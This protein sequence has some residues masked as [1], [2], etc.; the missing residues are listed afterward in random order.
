MLS[1]V[2]QHCDVKYLV[3][4]NKGNYNLSKLQH[5]YG[6]HVDELVL[7]N[8]HFPKILSLLVKII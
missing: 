4:F 5:E 6:N 8:I 3:V 2:D 7:G 1:I